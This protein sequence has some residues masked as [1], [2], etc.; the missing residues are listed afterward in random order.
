MAIIVP[1]ILVDTR[2]EALAKTRLVKARRWQIDVMDGRFVPN[3]TIDPR[4]LPRLAHGAVIEAH[5]MV[6]YPERYLRPLKGKVD[7]VVPHVEALKDVP[8]FV[9]HARVLGFKVGLAISPQ[10]PVSK[11][12]KHL[13]L[14]DYVLVMTVIPGRSGQPFL[15]RML[16]K[17]RTLRRLR[18]RNPASFLIGVDGGMHHHTVLQAAKA[19]ADIL[20][21]GSVL[22]RAASP[23]KAKR[24]LETEMAK[25]K[26][27]MMAKGKG[28]AAKKKGR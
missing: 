2:A 15:P 8:A 22:W 17:V 7:V 4:L 18:T 3:K 11:I 6:Y 5:L 24:L 19:G 14:L 28:N 9:R 23:A 12:T 26:T 13:P 25:A 16:G 10:T 27:G 21:A 1:S 20:I